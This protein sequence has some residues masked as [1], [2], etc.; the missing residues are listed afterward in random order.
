MDQNLLSYDLTLDVTDEYSLSEKMVHYC[1]GQILQVHWAACKAVLAFFAG[2]R[3]SKSKA[4]KKPEMEREYLEIY[5][6]AIE[7]LDVENFNRDAHDYF[8][9]SFQKKE[10]PMP[11]VWPRVQR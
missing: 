10:E 4:S 7:E 8:C 1:G 3:V 6:N 5:Y 2:S 11:E 9:H